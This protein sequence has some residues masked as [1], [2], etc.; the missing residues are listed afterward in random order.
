LKEEFLI[1]FKIWPILIPKTGNMKF[2]KKEIQ[3]C[4][5]FCKQIYLASHFHDFLLFPKFLI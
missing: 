3:I 1:I 4:A 2:I 5:K